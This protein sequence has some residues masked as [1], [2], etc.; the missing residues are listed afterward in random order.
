MLDAFLNTVYRH[1]AEK[2]ASAALEE[3]LR[4]MPSDLV[5]KIAYGSTPKCVGD[6]A[7]VKCWLDNFKGTPLFEK[8]VELE[9]ADL[10]LEQAEI[11]QR[12][13]N[14]ANDT[15]TKRDALRL[16]K[17]MLELDLAMQGVG[18]AAGAVPPEAAEEAAIG[19][20]EQVQAEEAAA[21]EGNKPEE[22]MENA[23]IEQLHAAH[24]EGDGASP[25]L[26][27]PPPPEKAPPAGPHAAEVPSGP[28]GAQPKAPPKPPTKKEPP[29]EEGKPAEDEKQAAMKVAAADAAGRLLAKVAEPA[30]P[31]GMSV[32]DWD[33][34]LQKKAAATK[35]AVEVP[36]ST[37]VA[38][39]AGANKAHEHGHSPVAGALRG[40][41]GMEGGSALGGGLGA[42][43]G[44]LLARKLKMDHVT[45]GNVGRLLGSVAGGV[46]GYRALT[47][48][49]EKKEAKEAA[50]LSQNAREHIKPSNFAEPKADGPGDTGKYPIEDKK[51]ARAALGL[52]GM[53]GS[54]AEKSKVR[55]AVAKKYPG[56][57][58]S[59]KTAGIGGVVNAA[60]AAVPAIAGAAKAGGSML[61]TAY[62]A[63]GLGQV[64]KSVGNVATGFAK[65]NPLAAAGAAGAAGIAA[66]RLSK[67]NGQPQA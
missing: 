43:G 56:L 15:W 62:K 49:L 11:E 16:Q 36:W 9:R 34:E 38:G 33:K 42:A 65:A 1:E 35:I 5:E 21:G 13:N 26:P 53:H 4:T 31:K 64:A 41:A 29:K 19:T 55:S 37:L 22:Q 50:V 40:A 10:Q 8:A 66:G 60:K 48:G 7:D 14:Q 27:P 18:G 39:A 46:G 6:S 3:K 61:G 17:R 67:G 28:P 30:P 24:G 51:H 23:A 57:S 52:V 47:H 25:P 63:G 12:M 44:E 58:G 20:L 32:K 54:D 2:T 45:A 59:D